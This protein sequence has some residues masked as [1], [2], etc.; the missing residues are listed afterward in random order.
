MTMKMSEPTWWEE[1]ASRVLKLS[2]KYV[3]INWDDEQA[4]KPTR[5][6]L[7]KL[8]ELLSQAPNGLQKS[9]PVFLLEEDCRKLLEWKDGG[10]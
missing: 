2:K 6:G 10:Q 9:S 7:A 1:G 3:K 5:D 8:R 4:P